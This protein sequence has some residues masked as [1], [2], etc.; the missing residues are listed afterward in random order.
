LQIPHRIFEAESLMSN[1]IYARLRDLAASA[2][3]RPDEMRPVLL[4]VVADLF[5]LHPQHTPQEI[6]L[7]EEMAGKLIDDADEPTLTIVARKLAR[8][9]DAPARILRRIRARGGAP[10]HEILLAGTQIEWTELR[11]IAASGACEHACAVAGRSDLDR[12]LTGILASRPEREI[13]RALAANALA[14]LAVENLRLLAARGREDA[15]LARALLDRGDLTLD[16]LPLYLAANAHERA[17][18]VSMAR[19]V[20]ILNAGRAVAA[21]PL[22]EE[23][24]ARL[25]AG[26]LRQ[27]RA[28]FAL[29]LAEILDCDPLCARR[30]VDDETGDAMTLAFI[31]VGLP[32]EIAVRIFLIAFPKVALSPE[33][34]ERNLR[35]LDTLPHRD[36]L[37]VVAAITGVT[38]AASASLRAQA[39]RAPLGEAQAA[40]KP[41]A[42]PSGIRYRLVNSARM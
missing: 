8:C 16:C 13:A 23:S 14:P 35:M 1:D 31:A 12:E 40:Q 19:G 26:A 10:A 24:C 11:Q 36:A 17:R 41:E 38:R 18:L 42:K 27:K 21:T 37:R 3:A 39:R 7:F 33:S 6:R 4:R 25:E 5:V 15:V 34:F 2:E 32:K 29:T 28:S 22:D 9:A 20:G 30:I